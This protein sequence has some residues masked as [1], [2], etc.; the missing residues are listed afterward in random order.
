M[1]RASSKCDD[2]ERKEW[3]SSQMLTDEQTN[4]CRKVDDMQTNISGSRKER[5]RI[6][7]QVPLAQ[8]PQTNRNTLSRR[9]MAFFPGL[10]TETELEAV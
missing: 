1:T 10:V 4:R 6:D 8:R 2:A 7:R 9:V 5:S 3:T